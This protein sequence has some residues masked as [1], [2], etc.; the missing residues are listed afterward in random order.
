SIGRSLGTNF[1]AP[2]NPASVGNQSTAAS[3][4]FVTTPAGTVPGHRTMAGAL[5]LPSKGVFRKSPRQGPFDPGPTCGT[6]P[7]LALSLERTTMVLSSTPASL[8]AS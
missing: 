2:A 1:A 8:T 6:A 7:P 4:S 5:I 3:I